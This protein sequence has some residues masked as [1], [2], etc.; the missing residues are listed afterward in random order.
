MY[1][2]FI[3]PS[4]AYFNTGVEDYLTGILFLDQNDIDRLIKERKWY[5]E[6]FNDLLM[7]KMEEVV[8][9]CISDLKKI[10]ILDASFL[11]RG[12]YT[13]RKF[14]G[15]WDSPERHYSNE[16]NSPKYNLV[17]KIVKLMQKTLNTNEIS[18]ED[19][20]KEISKNHDKSKLWFEWHSTD[21]EGKP[22]SFYAP[23]GEGKIRTLAL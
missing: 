8:K 14:F 15:R 18:L 6:N 4:S 13:D 20:I 10:T 12:G 1:S 16:H 7:E 17:Y 23:L 21:D 3:M 9:D 11:I 22:V 2:L 5:I 19:F